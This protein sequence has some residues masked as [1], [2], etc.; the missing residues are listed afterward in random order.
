MY[1]HCFL[2]YFCLCKSIKELFFELLPH[3]SARKRMQRY[4]FLANLQ[5][6]SSIFFRK[7]VIFTFFMESNECQRALHLIIYYKL[8]SVEW[9]VWSEI[10]AEIKYSYNKPLVLETF[11]TPHSTLLTPRNDSSLHETTPHPSKKSR[12][13]LFVLWFF[14]TFAIEK[15][16]SAQSGMTFAEKLLNTNL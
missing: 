11:L 15:L 14:C 12:N 7:S 8:W 10:S 5:N 2:Y 16:S 9:G 3:L 13:C 6:F 1:W 4:T